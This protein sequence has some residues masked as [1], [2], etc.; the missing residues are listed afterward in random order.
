MGAKVLNII[1]YHKYFLYFLLFYFFFSYLCSTNKLQ[2]IHIA[3]TIDEN[4]VR[5]CTVV[6]ASILENNKMDDITFHIV[7]NDLTGNS[8]TIISN[9]VKNSKALVSFYTV[10][11]LLLEA[12]ELK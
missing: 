12:Y 9:Q 6:M 11:S 5:Y 10:P 7:A 4:Y 8:K 1:E 3:L 2:M